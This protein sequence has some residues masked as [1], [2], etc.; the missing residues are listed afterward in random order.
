MSARG[1]IAR[2]RVLLCACVLLLAD[3]VFCGFYLFCS[4]CGVGSRIFINFVLLLCS[5]SLL[6]LLIFSRKSITINP[7]TSRSVVG[8]EGESLREGEGSDFAIQAP[9]P[10]LKK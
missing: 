4:F 8:G 9:S 10:S 7:P 2:D 1:V 3:F 5:K 6:P